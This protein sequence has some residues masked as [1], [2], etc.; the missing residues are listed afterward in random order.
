MIRK[1]S[2]NRRRHT[3]LRQA[4]DLMRARFG[5]QHWW[6][7]E[8]PFEVCV[9][10]ILTQNT[11]WKNVE[12]ALSALKHAR[13]LKPRPLHALDASTLARWLRP[14][15]Y[16]NVKARR[17]RAFLDVLI[18]EF[19]GHPRR[20]LE[21]PTPVV[22]ER[23][24]A[25]KG[26][27]PETADSILLYAGGHLSFVIDAYT[28]RIFARHGWCGKSATY[29]ELQTLC[30]SALLNRPPGRRLDH[31]QDYHAQLVMV[32]KDFCRPSNPRCDLCPLAPLLP[33][34][35]NISGGTQA[36]VLS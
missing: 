29:G 22:R 3:A 6:P 17:L 27:G 15:G 31:W 23:L 10:A 34:A 24:L 12:R 36:S 4:Y 30:S 28:K 2:R 21:G 8:T 14:T 35:R 20:M 18:R 16:F 25:I 1:P 26:I 5:H 9:G 13:L 7:G 11:S 32:G 19:D 33:R